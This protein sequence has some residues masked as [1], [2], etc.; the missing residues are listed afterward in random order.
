VGGRIRAAA[1][2]RESPGVTDIEPRDATGHWR[3]ACSKFADE[4]GWEREPI[5]FWFDQCASVREMHTGSRRE[6]AEQMAFADVC[7]IFDQRG[8]LAD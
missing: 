2:H 1:R 4:L 5:W 7:F 6:E 3:R 8:R